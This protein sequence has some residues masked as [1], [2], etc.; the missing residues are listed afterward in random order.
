MELAHNIE[1]W[2]TLKPVAGKLGTWDAKVSV[3]VWETGET[4]E[5]KF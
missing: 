3:Y 4:W 1:R 5:Q 2:E